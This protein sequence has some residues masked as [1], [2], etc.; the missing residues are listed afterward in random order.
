M[1][2]IDRLKKK[3]EKKTWY[4]T[5]LEPSIVSLAL[6]IRVIWNKRI[7]TECRIIDYVL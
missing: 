3:K 4:I 1:Y 6:D 2:L 7:V 5:I